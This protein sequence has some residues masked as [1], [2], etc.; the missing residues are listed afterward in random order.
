MTLMVRQLA[1]CQRLADRDLCFTNTV[2]WAEYEGI[3]IFSTMSS[4]WWM[5]LRIHQTPTGND[6]RALTG[7]FSP[8]PQTR[9]GHAPV[10]HH[11]FDGS[12]GIVDAF[13]Q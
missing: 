4:P 6:I 11:P 7:A 3:R 13:H 5:S 1:G 8:D 10:H 12:V 2:V 9:R